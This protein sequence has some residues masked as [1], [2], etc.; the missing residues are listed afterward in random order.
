MKILNSDVTVTLSEC[1]KSFLA[2]SWK[3][4]DSLKNKDYITS[5]NIIK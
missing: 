3:T 2:K 5:F 1:Y 4:V